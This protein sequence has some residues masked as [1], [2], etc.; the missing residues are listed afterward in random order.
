MASVHIAY[1]DVPQ[2]H[3]LTEYAPK[4]LIQL[5]TPQLILFNWG[6][7]APNN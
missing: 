4:N 3:I 6:T 2:N 7:P 1:S 5:G